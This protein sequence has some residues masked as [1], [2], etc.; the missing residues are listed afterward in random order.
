MPANGAG[1]SGPDGR[2]ASGRL[3][4]ASM[5]R[6]HSIALRLA[7]C[8]L[9]VQSFSLV[10]SCGSRS[11]ATFTAQSSTPA[12]AFPLTTRGRFIVDANG[13]RVR[14]KAFNWYG[15]ESPDAVVGGL[16]YQSLDTIVTQ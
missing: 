4:E 9:V 1:A 5:L 13:Q 11:Q 15:A 12:I 8:A 6:T 3:R 10:P 7:A 14:L 2:R 16:A